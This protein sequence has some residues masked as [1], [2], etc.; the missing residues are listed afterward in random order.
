M[1]YWLKYEYPQVTEK[2]WYN[3][4]G[5]LYLHL[6]EFTER[7]CRVESEDGQKHYQGTEARVK[8]EIAWKLLEIDPDI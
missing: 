1:R 6:E 3:S 4:L 7:F 5:E 8:G 2:I